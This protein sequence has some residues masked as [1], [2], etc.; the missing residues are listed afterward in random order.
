MATQPENV[1]SPFAGCYQCGA[2]RHARA[3][4]CWMCGA[5]QPAVDQAP[6]VAI[7]AE[8]PPG[9][10]GQRIAIWIGVVVAAVIGFGLLASQDWIWATLF[11]VAVVPT[12]L[13]VLIG[14]TSARSRGQPWTPAKTT[15]VAVATAATTVV[16][17]IAIVIVAAAVAVLVLFA[18]MIALFEQCLKAL[19]GGS[20]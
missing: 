16:S 3:K 4:Y 13:V 20:W 5:G 1:E 14:T 17:T 6:P 2:P 18:A 11:A 15:T 9:E 19:G 7:V 8:M 10:S 12:L